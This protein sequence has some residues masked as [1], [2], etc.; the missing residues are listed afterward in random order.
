VRKVDEKDGG[1]CGVVLVASKGKVWLEK[2]Y[3]VADAAAKKEMPPDA[4][5]DWASVSK[6]FTAGAMLRLI[7]ASRQDAAGLEK[8]GLKKLADSLDRKWRKLDLDDPLSRF[9]PDAPKDK[10]AV[11]LRQLLNHTS[12]IESGFK[13]EWKFDSRKRDAFVDLVLHLP[14]T[15][16]PGEKW[17][18]SNSGYAFVAAIVETVSGTTF[19]EFCA[20]WLFEPAGMKSATNIGRPEL[21]LG[22]VPK[23]ARGVGFTDRPKEYSFAYGNQLNWGYRGCGGIVA[24]TEDMLAW[25]RALRGDSF[26]PKAALDELYRPGRNGYALGWN[27]K[28]VDGGVR[29]EHGGGVF[30]VVTYYLRH[31]ERDFMVALACSYEPKSHPSEIAET[32]ARIVDKAK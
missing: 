14:M 1:F 19:E 26:L 13:Q 8:L 28:K 10:A 22:R 25:D 15:A 12:G 5:Y 31:L 29:V 32:L 30:G 24:S 18:Y 20:K 6:Q 17:E 2:G 9:F 7:E 4:L 21:D 3:G 27:V 16:K 23:I 11:T